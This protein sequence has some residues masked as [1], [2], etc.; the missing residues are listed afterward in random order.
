[1]NNEIKNLNN[2]YNKINM[3]KMNNQGKI[4]MAFGAGVDTNK[5]ADFNKRFIGVGEFEIAGVNANAK[6]IAAFYGSELRDE[7]TYHGT[8]TKEDG[9]EV[10]TASIEF[11]LNTK[12]GSKF[13][14]SHSLKTRLRFSLYKEYKYNRD[15]TKIACINQYGKCAYLSVDDLKNN[16][17][18]DNMAWF[19]TSAK[20]VRPAFKGEEELTEFLRAYINVPNK[21]YKNRET[22]MWEDI[23]DLSKAECRLEHVTDFFKGNSKEVRST[24]AMRPDNSVLAVVGVKEVDTKIYQD[25]FNKLF[26]KARSSREALVMFEKKIEEVQGYGAF[27]NTVFSTEDLHVYEIEASNVEGLARDGVNP[28]TNTADATVANTPSFDEEDLPF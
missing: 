5:V 11:L 9:K 4:F 22:G 8:F 23:D 19:A 24:I 15:N 10:Q 1:M 3:N 13:N 16:K 21:S 18:A 14:G 6:A 27:P 17:I 20:D 26:M 7:P 25:I 2:N 28:I 12:E